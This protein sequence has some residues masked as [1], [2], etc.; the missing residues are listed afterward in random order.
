MLQ[1]ACHD[2]LSVVIGTK[3]DLV[4][5]SSREVAVEEG[6]RLA[7]EV[8]ASHTNLQEV[9]YYETSSITGRNVNKVFE[10][11]FTKCL[12]ENKTIG[13]DKSTLDLEQSSNAKSSSGCCG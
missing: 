12:D 1:N 9:P 4:T 11:I 2:C 3:S 5:P 6:Y 10:Y 8:N 13:R 7:K